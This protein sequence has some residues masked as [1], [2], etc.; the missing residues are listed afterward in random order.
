MVSR[1]ANDS[2]QKRSVRNLLLTRRHSGKIVS[3]PNSSAVSL[4]FCRR[5]RNTFFGH[6]RRTRK[7]RRRFADRQ[8]RPGAILHPDGELPNGRPSTCPPTL[9]PGHLDS[10]PVGRSPPSQ[11][12]PP[13]CSP[14]S[15]VSWQTASAGQQLPRIAAGR[16]V[17]RGTLQSS[18][19]LHGFGACP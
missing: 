14:R 1:A 2:S 16:R 12:H 10:A 13:R 17:S 6:F 19:K 18:K 4:G 7:A 9:R 5:L 11:N 3:G 15:G 8:D